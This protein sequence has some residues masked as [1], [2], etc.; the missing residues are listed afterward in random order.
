MRYKEIVQENSI[1]L[2]EEM[3]REGFLDTVKSY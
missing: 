3:L 2:T 1:I